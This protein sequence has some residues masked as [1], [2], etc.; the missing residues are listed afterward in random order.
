MIGFPA[1]G[2]GYVQTNRH[3]WSYVSLYSCIEDLGSGMSLYKLSLL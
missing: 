2:A 3:L 1:G